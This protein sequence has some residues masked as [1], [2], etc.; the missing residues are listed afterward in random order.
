MGKVRSALLDVLG[1][2]VPERRPV[3]LMR[4]AGRYLPEYRELRG[5][6]G[7]FLSLCYNPVLAAEVTLQPLRRFDFDAAILFSDI[8][9]VPHALG[10]KLDFVEGEGPRLETVDDMAGIEALSGKG[11]GEIYSKVWETVARVKAELQPDRA[12]IGFCGGPWTVASYMIEGGSSD[13]K[14]AVNIA[15]ENPMWFGLLL[16]KL[17]ESSIRYMVGQVRAGAQVLQIFDSWAGDIPVALRQRVV[18]EP[19]ARI[20]AG[21][22]AAF[23]GFPII[24]FAR[25]VG[26]DHGRIAALTEATAIGVEDGISL[27]E[28]L[29]VVAPEIV[30]Q[31]NLAPSVLLGSVS[32]MRDRVLEVL[33]AIPKERHIFNLGHGIVPEVKPEM[34]GELVTAIR[35]FDRVS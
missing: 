7:S 16:D 10:L 6:A 19:I 23:P 32:A 5:Q 34:V 3:W 24:V 26:L 21:V 29:K 20:V 28:V 8:L 25:G 22:R 15:V 35:D 11:E 9:V 13:R 27:A 33:R 12:L 2:R 1:R 14:R 18:V 31:G 30:L 17:V 4:Q